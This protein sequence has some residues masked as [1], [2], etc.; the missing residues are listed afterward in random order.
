MPPANAA[1]EK[2]RRNDKTPYPVT[3]YAARDAGWLQKDQAGIAELKNVGRE[4]PAASRVM[5]AAL[6]EG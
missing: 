5:M 4:E 6:P 1:S 2:R 3:H